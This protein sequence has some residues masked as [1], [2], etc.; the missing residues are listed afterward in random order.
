MVECNLPKVEV[1]GSIPVSRFFPFS[2]Q[3]GFLLIQFIYFELHKKS[4]QD[5]SCPDLIVLPV[6]VPLHRVIL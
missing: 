2:L 4:G 6:T 1:A 3:S 5:C